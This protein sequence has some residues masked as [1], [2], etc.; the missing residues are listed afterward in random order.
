MSQKFDIMT[1]NLKHFDRIF[2]T[3]Y[4]LRTFGENL[5]LFL[6]GADMI[7]RN[8]WSLLYV[9]YDSEY[10]MYTVC[11]SEKRSEKKKK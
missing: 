4:A 10:N 1:R 2:L 5:R 3:L 7:H 9:S 6:R 8:K 11:N